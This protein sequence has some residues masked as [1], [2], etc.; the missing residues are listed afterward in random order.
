MKSKILLVDD[1]DAALKL[2]GR[3]LEDAGF[4]VLASSQSIGTTN[5]AK[6]FEPDVILLDVMMPALAGNKM[7]KLLQ[8]NVPRQPTIILLSNKEEDEL[9]KICQECGADDYVSKV[10]GPAALVRK[11][12]EHLTLRGRAS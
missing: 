2:F 8:E 6:D 9:K 4:E 10:S 3:A 11:V 12:R 1:D 5:R 7:V